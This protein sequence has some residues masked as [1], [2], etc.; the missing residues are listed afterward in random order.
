MCQAPEA[1]SSVPAPPREGLCHGRSSDVSPGQEGEASGVEGGGKPYTLRD[2]EA[3]QVS[4]PVGAH[5]LDASRTG[6]FLKAHGLHL[7]EFTME[8]QATK[9]RTDRTGQGTSPGGRSRQGAIEYAPL[10]AERL[11]DAKALL[12]PFWKRSW[13][14]GL[15]DRI[16]RWRFLERSD[17]EATLAY[18]GDRP[19]G[20]VDSFFTPYLTEAGVVRVRE[21]ADWF[22]HPDYRPLVGIRLLRSLMKKPE[23]ILIVG[24]RGTAHQI[25]S[26][27]GWSALPD[28]GQYVL[29]TGTGAMVKG[30]SKRLHFPLSSVPAVVARGLSF[31]MAPALGA[32]RR[33][34]EGKV[35]FVEDG[36]ALPRIQPAPG[37]YRLSSLLTPE[38]FAW[39]RRA[40]PELGR[41]FCL[42]FE[43][44]EGE[45]G[46]ALGRI[47]D[48]GP[49]RAGRIL[50][51]T[52]TA[53]TLETYAWMVRETAAYLVRDGAQWVTARFSSSTARDA[54]EAV[55]FRYTGPCA[56][57][58]WHPEA[59][60]L[61]GPTDLGW[62]TGD[63][64]VLPYPN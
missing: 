17:W 30:L 31:R 60:T 43:T 23:P 11:D 12:L 52:A 54:L 40:P 9:H 41:F 14:P 7:M 20:F 35:T 37:A 62:T 16:L 55:G 49:F 57:F 10:T 45:R 3:V 32:D 27:M 48:D 26:R 13:E 28:L 25:V 15:A 21:S 58:W 1:G 24:G 22:C 19:V 53:P 5:P 36:M 39:L 50:N 63:E 46:L 47:Y 42:A 6:G 8:R 29:P 18:D 38:S 33:P 51:L 34:V 64:G 4:P 56:A 59:P 44:G 61:D 2:G